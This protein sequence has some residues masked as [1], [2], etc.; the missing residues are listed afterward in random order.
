MGWDEFQAEKF[1]A[2]QN[3]LA[4]TVLTSW[5]VAQTKL[6][7]MQRFQRDPKLYHEL[8]AAL[9][10]A[11]PVANVRELLRAALPL[12]QLSPHQAAEL[13]VK[14]LVA[15]KPDRKES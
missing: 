8:E 4:L 5:F 14:H 12:P 15:Q 11:R 7:W 10:P 1:R 9:L 13:V 2:W 3:Q 6:Q